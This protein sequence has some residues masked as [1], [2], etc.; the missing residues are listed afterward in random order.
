MCFRVIHVSESDLVLLVTKYFQIR[1]LKSHNVS[2]DGSKE[3]ETAEGLF[4]LLSYQ[5][6][7]S[8]GVEQL[9]SI[10]HYPTHLTFLKRVFTWRTIKSQFA[11]SSLSVD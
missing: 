3:Y 7:R 1:K 4:G 6:I 2:G 9:Q 8:G 10:C 11:K 5:D